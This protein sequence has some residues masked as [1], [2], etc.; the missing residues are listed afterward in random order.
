MYIL[1]NGEIYIIKNKT[2][3]TSISRRIL[4]FLHM[5]RGDRDWSLEVDHP[6]SQK[7]KTSNA[8]MITEDISKPFRHFVL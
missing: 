1:T 5:R 3:K 2:K 6:S 7:N 4:H 8:K